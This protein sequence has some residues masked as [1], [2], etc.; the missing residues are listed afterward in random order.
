MTRRLFPRLLYLILSSSCCLLFLSTSL[1][2][3]TSSLAQRLSGRILLQ[4]EARGEAWYI[5]PLSQQRF[6]LGT[7]DDAFSLLRSKGLGIRHSDV[8]RYLRADRFPAR[9]SGRILID[10]GDRGQAYYI[11]PQTLRA[12]R[13]GTAQET[14]AVLRQTG[15]GITTRDLETI[16]VATVQIRIPT[17]VSVPET[18]LLTPSPSLSPTSTPPSSLPS[19]S[20]PSGSL[21]QR[22][23][24][25]INQHRISI[26][27]S[28]LTWNETV[29][30]VARIH[31]Q[32]MA[33]G[34]VAFGHDGF[35]G[36]FEQ[37]DSRISLS[38]MA[39]NVA[40]NNFDDPVATAVRGWLNSPGH[41][42]N[43]ENGLYTQTGIGV[44]KQGE[45]EY[46]FTQLF[47][48]PRSR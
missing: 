14:Y 9:L 19:S 18:P 7:A 8:E 28:P 2:A 1:Q 23:H 21:E 39:E 6:F 44:A 17:P 13:L 12:A 11:L 46:F 24:E 48:T 22:T 38:R 3:Q 10:V 36:R 31:S 42:I 30:D 43:I 33:E 27:L 32:N 29:A 26:G 41:R 5:D 15:L 45:D 37:V 16:P 25:A 47:I 35:D 4:V 40:S 34:R 20:T